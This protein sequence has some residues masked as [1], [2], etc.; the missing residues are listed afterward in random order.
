MSRRQRSRPGTTLMEMLVALAIFGTIVTMTLGMLDNQLRAFNEGTAQ[1]DALQNLRYT[2]SVLEKDLATVGINVSNEQPFLV[3]ADTTVLVFNADYTSRVANDPFATYI[4]PAAG[5]EIAMAVTKERRFTVPRTTLSYPDTTYKVGM[6]NSPAETITFYFEPDTS[7]ARPDDY[8]LMRKVNDQP[9]DLIARGVLSLDGRPFFEYIRRVEPVSA[10]AYVTPVPPDSLPLRH[11]RVLH[12]VA[13]D[14]GVLARIDRVRAVKVRFRIT[15]HRPG[16][17]ERIYAAMRTIWFANAGL[18]TR[19]TCGDLP[20]LGGVG[21]TASRV[22][23]GG[24]PAVQLSWSQA[25]DES[26]GEKDVI[27]YVIYRSTGPGPVSDPYLS[28]PAGNTSYSYTDSDV[29][30]G[31][32]YYYSIAAQDC[33]PSLSAVFGAAPVMVF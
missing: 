20:I 6:Q 16:R 7:T 22:M 13:A 10:P 14:T 3:Y 29:E 17:K 11:V 23:A 4:D 1:V 24:L 8:R 12:G 30:V 32:L 31:R 2:M 21:F 19:Q 15:D 28:I 18:A 9:A 26:G 27:R 33:S 5:D 25:T